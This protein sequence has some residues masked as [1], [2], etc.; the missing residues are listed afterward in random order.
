MA[1]MTCGR[2]GFRGFRSHDCA[3]AGLSKYILHSRTEY[4]V[5]LRY[6]RMGAILFQCYYELY[7]GSV[8]VEKKELE[9]W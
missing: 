5:I 6:R 7:R 4:F 1:S 9:L 2:M 8:N 3:S